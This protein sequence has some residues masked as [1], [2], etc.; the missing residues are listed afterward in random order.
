MRLKLHRALTEQKSFDL[1]ELQ[2]TTEKLMATQ[3]R[4]RHLLS[5]VV[6][7]IAGIRHT[8]AWFIREFKRYG[9]IRSNK[10]YRYDHD[11]NPADDPAYISIH[12]LPR[13]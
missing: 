3:S 7:M 5:G 4:Y 6:R 9:F 11:H 2:T 10:P 8:L 1:E 12:D 13:E